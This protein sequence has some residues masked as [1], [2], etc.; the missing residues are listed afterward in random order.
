M[1]SLNRLAHPQA[2]GQIGRKIIPV[3]ARTA[4]AEERPQLWARFTQY[5]N[6]AGYER[7]PKREIPVV[8]LTPAS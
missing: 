6:F 5:A 1:P 3:T 7:A 8:I 2:T 4:N